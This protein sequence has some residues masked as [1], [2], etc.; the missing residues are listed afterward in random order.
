MAKKAWYKASLALWR[1]REAFRLTRWHYWRA[2]DMKRPGHD[3]IHSKRVKWWGLFEEARKMRRKRED[4]IE[5]RWPRYARTVS[6]AGVAFVA[7][8]EG[9]QSKD[10]RFRP[11]KDPVGVWTIGYGETRGVGPFTEPWTEKQARARLKERLNRDFVPAVLDASSVPLKQHQ[12]DGLASFVYNVGVGG[13]APST[14]VG[15][16]LRRG[17]LSGAA[18]AML[19]WNKAGGKVLPGLAR[20]RE[21]ERRL[22]LR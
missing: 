10:G 1:R 16:E 7:A 5:A 3:D 17:N 12:L 14:R 11:Y 21:A 19:A 20:R 2:L 13:V 6:D 18:E 9:G 4:Q 22:I 8:F 15:R